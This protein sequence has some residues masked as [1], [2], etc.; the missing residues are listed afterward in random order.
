MLK[1]NPWE[2]EDEQRNECGTTIW[3]RVG[4]ISFPYT[5]GDDQNT[6]Q[7]VPKKHN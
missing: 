4:N 5:H 1:K 6:D 7:I 3:M 2:Y